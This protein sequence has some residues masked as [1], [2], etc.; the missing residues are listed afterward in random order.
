MPIAG[1]WEDKLESW[2]A[3]LQRE[4]LCWYLVTPPVGNK[5]ARS[6]RLPENS[7]ARYLH[8]ALGRGS[9]VR[10]GLG[11]Q[12]C[13]RREAI[14]ASALQQRLTPALTSKPS[15]Q[16]EPTDTQFSSTHTPG[17]PNF[18]LFLPM[19]TKV[20]RSVLHNF[21]WVTGNNIEWYATNNIILW[22]FS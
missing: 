12:G 18:L 22:V 17:S 13:Y 9:A 15:N 8:W 10:C 11:S 20:F 6:C 4:R 2:T 3:F 1:P 7:T 21:Y 5:L 16:Q 19:E 14:A